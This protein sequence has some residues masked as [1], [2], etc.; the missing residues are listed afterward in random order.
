MWLHV[1]KEL[2]RGFGSWGAGVTDGCDPLYSGTSNQVC[3]LSAAEPP[4]QLLPSPCPLQRC[5]HLI[6]RLYVYRTVCA[7]GVWTRVHTH[8]HVYMC[9]F[10]YSSLQFLL[11]ILDCHFP[12]LKHIDN[13]SKGVFCLILF[14]KLRSRPFPSMFW[15]K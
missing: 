10:T 9:V 4:L 7:H 3:E 8:G 14:L 6:S 2:T 11:K 12:Y 15:F 1:H 5:Q 13:W